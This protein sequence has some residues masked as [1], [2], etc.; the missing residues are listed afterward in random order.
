MS[1]TIFTKIQRNNYSYLL[2]R[3]PSKNYRLSYDLNKGL[4]SKEREYLDNNELM[5]FI[6]WGGIVCVGHRDYA[7]WNWVE[8]PF[9]EFKLKI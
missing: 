8:L 6:S 2:S 4:T 5:A 3:F 7:Q 9:D 1:M